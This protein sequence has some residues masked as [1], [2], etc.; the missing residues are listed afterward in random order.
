MRALV[1]GLALLSSCAPLP[2]S[3]PVPEQ[4]VGEEG[5]EPE[6]LGA[7]VTFA[8][9]RAEDYAVKGFLPA[10]PDQ[11]WR[12]AT[13]NPTLRFRVSDVKGLRL[14]ANFA[15]PEGS[16]R[17]L[18]PI[19]VKYFV[20]EQLLEAV[21]YKNAGTMEYRKGVPA[22]W[23]KVDTDNLV[24]MEISPVYVAEA[25]KQKLSLILSEIGLEQD[26]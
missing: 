23:L 10:A 1:L 26:K 5:Q 14:R 24:R 25:D 9:A 21:V 4:R 19:T 3:Y 7:F 18:L 8:D 2:E 15:F 16:H 22:E 6:P 11:T 13:E 20:N 17:A 12:W